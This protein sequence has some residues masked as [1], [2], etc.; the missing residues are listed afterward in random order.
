MTLGH[1]HTE[2]HS[3]LL[4]Q[5]DGYANQGNG[6]DSKKCR[7]RAVEHGGGESKQSRKWTSP[8]GHG[9]SPKCAGTR[10]VG[11]GNS[12]RNPSQRRRV[13]ESLQINMRLASKKL[14]PGKARLSV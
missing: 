9:F 6:E 14:Y 12:R 10:G 13:L 2:K 4:D 5:R 7:H 11:L 8:S 1:T 3:P